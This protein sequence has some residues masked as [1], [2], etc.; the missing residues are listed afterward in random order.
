LISQLLLI[1]ASGALGSAHCVGMCGGFAAMVGMPARSAWA[2]LS[3]Q[4]AYSGGRIATYSMLGVM[5][6]YAGIRLATSSWLPN[7]L[8]VVAVL[9]ILCGLFLMFE[10]A[11]AAGTRLLPRRRRAIAIH[12]CLSTGLVSAFLKSP[13]LPHAFLAGTFTGFLP[14]GLVY[15]FLALAAAERDPLRGMGVMFAFGLGTVPLM[16]LTGV[17]SAALTATVRRRVLRLAA[18]CVALTG[19]L[20]V[21]RGVGFF[22]MTPTEPVQCPFCAASNAN[23][24]DEQH[25]DR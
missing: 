25:D 15:G 4:L 6:G 8:N 20:T 18:V 10:G 9:T 23:G 22:R 14:C 24:E 5:A 21:Y 2:A 11:R 1:A 13:G 3:R 12:P 17:G 19:A 7:A 16:V